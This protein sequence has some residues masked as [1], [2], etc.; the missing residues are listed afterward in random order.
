M[1]VASNTKFVW[2]A[3]G[4]DSHTEGTILGSLSAADTYAS[5]NNVSTVDGDSGV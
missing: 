1:A 2:S 5:A 4:V 3:D